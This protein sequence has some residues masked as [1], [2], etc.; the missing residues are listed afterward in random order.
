MVLKTFL[1]SE[2]YTVLSS[3][4]CVAVKVIDGW[5]NYAEKVLQQFETDKCYRCKVPST[6]NLKL[7]RSMCPMA[8]EEKELMQNKLYQSAIGNLIYLILGTLAYLS[9]PSKYMNFA[10]ACCKSG[11]RYLKETMKWDLRLGGTIFKHTQTKISQ[12]RVD[13]RNFVAGY[14]P[15]LMEVPSRGVARQKERSHSVY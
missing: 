13:N 15:Q 12:N 8:K 10:L 3:A 1:E 9:I 5:L 7:S 14:L 11:F 2:D 6:A 4:I